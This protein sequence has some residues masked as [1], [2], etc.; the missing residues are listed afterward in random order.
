MGTFLDTNVIV[1]AFDRAE[2]EKQARARSILAGSLDSVAVS[3]QIL[4]E[5]YAV[6]T[7]K[8]QPALSAR[9]AGEAAA[10]LSQLV[11]VVPLDATLVL[12]AMALAQAHHLS[13]WDAQIIVAAQRAGCTTL[14]T[15]DLPDGQTIAGV[16]LRNPFV[17]P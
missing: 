5:F 13:L 15:E 12:S 7:R 6:V 3:S 14:L 2:P 10:H 17:Q 9:A 4:S 8:L 11:T 16:A 1:Y